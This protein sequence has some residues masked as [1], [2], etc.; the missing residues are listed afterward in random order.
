MTELDK[1][2]P[3]ILYK[4]RDDSDRTEEII[5]NKK[6]WLSSPIQLNDPLECR[7]GEIPKDWEERT[8][9]EL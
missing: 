4:Y 1:I 9:F 7:I 6:I 3:E 8:I 2:K 5:K